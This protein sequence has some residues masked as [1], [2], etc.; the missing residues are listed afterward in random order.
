MIPF[1]KFGAPIFQSRYARLQENGKI[2]LSMGYFES[3]KSP[4][5]FCKELPQGWV[6]ADMRGTKEVPIWEDTRP[7]FYW[8]FDATTALWE[9]RRTIKTELRRAV[10]DGCPCRLSFYWY[11][12]DEFIE[13]SASI[14]EEEGLFEWDD[15]FC[16][17]CNTDFKNEGSFCSD[18]CEKDYTESLKTP[19]QACGQKIELFK[20]IRHHVSYYPE[21]VIFVHPSCH[22]KIHKTDQFPNLRPSDE[23]IS[24]FYDKSN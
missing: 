4:N 3:R 22:N 1:D 14:D 6:Y 9:R 18:K 11:R 20:E 15:G 16:R 19:C 12:T 24:K 21:K 10:K 2:L 17:F 13:V 5:L 23:E 7:L 8:K